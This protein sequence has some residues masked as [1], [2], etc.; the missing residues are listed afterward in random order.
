[1]PIRKHI[2]P[3]TAEAL[4]RQRSHQADEGHSDAVRA[5]VK[6]ALVEN[7][8]QG[9]EDSTVGL[10]HFINEGHIGFRKVTARLAYVQVLLQRDHR[11]RAKQ[12]LG[13]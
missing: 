13:E 7:G 11:Q 4:D 3:F 9:V 10:E 1:M 8:E 6:G 12:L 2:E 5:V